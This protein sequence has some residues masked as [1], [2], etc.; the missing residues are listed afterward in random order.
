MQ[1]DILCPCWS[2]KKYHD[3]CEK[4]HKGNLPETALALMRSRYSAY[5]LALADYIM[6][7][8]H[9]K[10][11]IA[12]MEKETRRKEILEFSRKTHFENLEILDFIDGPEIAYVT[13]KAHL[14][15]GKKDASF[16]EKSRFEKINGRWLYWDGIIER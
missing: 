2:K 1:T 11:P 6:L 9:P 8:T 3:C 13:F 7:T 10:N 5:A 14:K 16:L 12:I 4:Y 15:Q